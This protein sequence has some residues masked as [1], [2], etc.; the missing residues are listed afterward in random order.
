MLNGNVYAEELSLAEFDGLKNEILG[1]MDVPVPKS[2]FSKDLTPRINSG[3]SYYAGFEIDTVDMHNTMLTLKNMSQD[4]NPYPIVLSFTVSDN[5]F[6]NYILKLGNPSDDIVIDL[7]YE[8]SYVNEHSKSTVCY[9]NIFCDFPFSG[10][11]HQNS[12]FLKELQI[13]EPDEIKTTSRSTRSI[14]LPCCPSIDS[15]I[16]IWLKSKETGA[17]NPAWLKVV[18]GACQSGYCAGELTC[19]YPNKGDVFHA[20]IPQQIYGYRCYVIYHPY[21]SDE[22]RERQQYYETNH[23]DTTFHVSEKLKWFF[24]GEL[25]S[26]SNYSFAYVTS[27]EGPNKGNIWYISRKGFY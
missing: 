9:I 25:L 19:Y 4:G 16:Y 18:R 6:H 22:C 12:S 8:A 2:Y 17:T 13:I 15:P 7:S 21:T 20:P 23:Y 5:Q 27:I 24:I 26:N 11:I 1:P 3:E 14:T 10:E